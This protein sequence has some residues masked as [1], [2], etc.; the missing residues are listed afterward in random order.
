VRC[1]ALGVHAE[2]N[3]CLGCWVV[4]LVIVPSTRLGVRSKSQSDSRF[5]LCGLWDCC[6]PPVPDGI[7][8]PITAAK[9]TSAVRVRAHAVADHNSL[10]NDFDKESSDAGFGV[11]L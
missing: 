11:C 10:T 4:P 3:G 9:L 1:A 7:M 2:R 6:S 5:L 8:P